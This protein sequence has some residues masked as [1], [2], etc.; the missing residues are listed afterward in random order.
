MSKSQANYACTECGSLS[1]QWSGSCS[2]CGAWNTLAPVKK[3]NLKAGFAGQVTT[4]ALNLGAVTLEENE[5]VSSGLNEL[6]LV[7]GGGIVR[8]S[9]V[10]LGGDPGIGKSTILLQCLANLTKPNTTLYV[11]GEESPQQIKLRANRLNIQADD[12]KILPATN[13]EVILQQIQL[14]KPD[15]VVIDSI[16]TVYLEQV[17]SAPGSISQ[18][19]ES[20]AKLVQYAKQNATTIFLIG[21]VTKEGALAG[22]RI[23]E[24]MVDTVLYFEGDTNKRFRLLRAVKNRFGAANELGIFAMCANGLKEVKNPSAIFLSGNQQS[25]PGRIIMASWEG[26][27]P[28]LVEVQALVTESFLPNPRRVA[29]GVEQNRLNILLAVLHQKAG[30]MLHNQD[31]F[32]N[33]VGG[34]KLT[35]TATDVPILMAVFSSLKNIAV[36]TSQLAFGEVG[37]SGEIR[38][39]EYGQERLKEAAKLGFKSAVVPLANA[40][41]ANDCQDIKTLGITTVEELISSI[42]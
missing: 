24:H 8:G 32:I 28:I 39:I 20:A 18:V 4:Q 16:Q 2:A 13:V 7:L 41:K 25:E 36:A 1:Y 17:Q 38:P 34:I 29:V 23:L 5:R 10:L 31:V 15:I 40:P 26:S 14:E 11:S 6:D 27:R 9:V 19:R 12:I 37:L 42:N 35:E 33:V 21:H 22:P 3:T 30:V